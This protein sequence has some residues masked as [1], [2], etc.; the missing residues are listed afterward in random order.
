MAT[1]PGGKI[2]YYQVAQSVLDENT[3]KREIKPLQAIKDNY[4]KFIL[5]R[6]YNTGNDNGIEIVNVLKWLMQ[7]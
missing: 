6:D 3:F 7:G 5:T 1:M 2:E 4:P